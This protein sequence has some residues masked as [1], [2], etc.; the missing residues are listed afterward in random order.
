MAEKQF[1]FQ[2][3]RLLSSAEK[4]VCTVAFND[5]Y[6]E[7]EGIWDTSAYQYGNHFRIDQGK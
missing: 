2:L 6:M 7:K 3:Q 4:C 1:L 5:D